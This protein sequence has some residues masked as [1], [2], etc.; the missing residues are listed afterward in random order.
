[1]KRR[2]EYVYLQ[3]VQSRHN[4]VELTVSVREAITEQYIA[5]IVGHGITEGLLYYNRQV[6]F[7][8]NC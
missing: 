4:F 6:L 1:M 3:S 5:D 8:T 2:R 7:N